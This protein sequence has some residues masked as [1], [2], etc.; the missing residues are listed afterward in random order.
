MRPEV[1]FA[2]IIFTAEIGDRQLTR[3]PFELSRL[4][5]GRYAYVKMRH[6]P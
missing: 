2:E 3:T 1:A 4:R 5:G 6:S